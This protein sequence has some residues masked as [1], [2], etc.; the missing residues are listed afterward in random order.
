MI[1]IYTGNGKGKTTS[2]LGLIMR[3]LGHNMKICLIQFMKNNWEYGEIKFLSKQKNV[4]IYK[5]GSDH[6]VDMQNPAAIDYKEA[7][8]ACRKAHAIISADK[9]DIVVLDEINVAVYMKLIDLSAQLELM[10]IGTG[11]EIIMTGRHAAEEVIKKADLV[12]EIVEVKHYY[13]RGTASRKGIEF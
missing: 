3:A 9:Y 2:A 7:E 10:D 8:N 13:N 11:S 5:F 1:Q 12:S 4:D 6:F